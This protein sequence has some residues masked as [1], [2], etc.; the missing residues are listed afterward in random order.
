MT[1]EIAA[2]RYLQSLKQAARDIERRWRAVQ[3]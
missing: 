3:A 1:P 2:R